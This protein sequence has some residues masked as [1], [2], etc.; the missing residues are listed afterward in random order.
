MFPLLLSIAV[1]VIS[2]PPNSMAKS[3]IRLVPFITSGDSTIASLM[4]LPTEASFD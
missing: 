3:V 2:V 4:D 1:A